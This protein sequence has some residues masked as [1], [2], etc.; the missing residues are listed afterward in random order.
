MSQEPRLT[1]KRALSHGDYLE[2][3]RALAGLGEVIDE[4]MLKPFLGVC[5]EG[6][7]KAERHFRRDAGMAVDEVVQGLSGD[8]EHPRAL[9]HSERMRL[10]ALAADKLPRMQRFNE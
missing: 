8:T 10:K 9:D 4:L 1:L 3:A 2:M 7:G 6:L 5:V